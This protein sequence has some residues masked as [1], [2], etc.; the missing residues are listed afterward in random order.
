M[1]LVQFIF[2]LSLFDM[3]Y[4]PMLSYTR[5]G[6]DTVSKMNLNDRKSGLGFLF[7]IFPSNRDGFYFI[8]VQPVK[9]TVETDWNGRGGDH[10]DGQDV[11]LL[12][13][14]FPQIVPNDTVETCFF[15]VSPFF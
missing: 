3:V 12:R 8:F 7:K 15:I 10:D 14:S 1:D 2:L 4:R 6:F 9:C 11:A 5:R 13:H